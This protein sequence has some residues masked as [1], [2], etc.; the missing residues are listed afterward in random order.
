MDN[1]YDDEQAAQKRN[2]RSEALS[3]QNAEL[4][5]QVSELTRANN[6]LQEKLNTALVTGTSGACT[7][8][9]QEFLTLMASHKAL[10]G[11]PADTPIEDFTD[12]MGIMALTNIHKALQ[13]ANSI[14]H[15]RA[16]TAGTR[17]GTAASKHMDVD[18][19]QQRITSLE[20]ELHT[21]LL[22]AEDIRLLKGKLMSLV[23]RARIDKERLIKA[24]SE[25]WVLQGAAHVC[26]WEYEGV[27]V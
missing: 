17:T 7:E 27:L 15:G 14:S 5:E 19:M 26:A 20:D 10:L 25:W 3:T 12:S 24:E 21:A 9:K 2:G 1:E 6:M 13:K 16:S 4:K 18:E 11:M 23:E 8:L 22:S